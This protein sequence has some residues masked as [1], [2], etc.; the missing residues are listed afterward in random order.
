[1]SPCHHLY[2]S[3]LTVHI[4]LATT[5]LY[6]LINSKLIKNIRRKQNIKVVSLIEQVPDTEMQFIVLLRGP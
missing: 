4:A 1:M 2:S 6:L 5:H 3:W